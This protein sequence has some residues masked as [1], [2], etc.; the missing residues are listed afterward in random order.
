MMDKINLKVPAKINLYLRVLDKRP[1]G[2]HNIDSLMQTISLYDEITL[3][4][5]DEIELDCR[6]LGNLAPENN[7]AYRAAKLV[8]TMAYFPGVRIVLKK[9]IP[10]GAGLG[11][12]SADAAFVIRGLIKLF[13]LQLDSM[14][15][16]RRTV[17]VGSDIP[18][19]LGRGQAHI[20]GIG[21][22]V[23]DCVLPLKY[24]VLLVKPLF[25]VDTAKAYGELDKCREGKFLLTN[26]NTDT[27][28]Y[29]IIA[30]HNFVRI[31]NKFIN[32]LEEVVFSWHRELFQVKSRLYDAGAFYSGMTG[33]GSSIFGLFSPDSTV[34]KTARRF[35][36]NNYSVFVCRP[37]LLPPAS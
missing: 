19:F 27:F 32:D 28:L 30:D 34:E 36:E 29:R 2:Y 26:R 15:L 10:I 25:S 8:E 13:D 22:T 1:D 16:I 20:G 33:S 31:A 4:R 21:D 5:S 6:D 35:I 23:R 7:L 3:E 9:K 11:G 17:Q 37:V 24:K 12:G 18:F 14:E